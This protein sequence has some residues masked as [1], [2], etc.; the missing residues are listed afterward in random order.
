MS[1]WKRVQHTVYWE[2]YN[3]YQA[4]LVQGLNTK[5]NYSNSRGTGS[6]GWWW[7][8]ES[9]SFLTF[10]L[11]ALSSCYTKATSI[12][13]IFPILSLG[14]PSANPSQGICI[15]CKE[16]DWDGLFHDNLLN[17]P[18]W[19]DLM[20]PCKPENNIFVINVFSFYFYSCEFNSQSKYSVSVLTFSLLLC[21]RIE[22]SSCTSHHRMHNTLLYDSTQHQLLIWMYRYRSILLCSAP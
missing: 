10:G 16:I 5:L 15:D 19:R 2:M 11:N 22:L 8:T 9:S 14:L 13:W 18:F 21:C 6:A 3:H 20:R 1:I 12:F 7:K 17:I 4:E